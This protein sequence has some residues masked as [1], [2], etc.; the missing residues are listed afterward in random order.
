MAHPFTV[1]IPA[2]NEARVIG[3]TLAAMASDRGEDE[4]LILVVCN[5]CS[6]ETAEFARAAAPNAEV[7]EIGEASKTA[8]INEGLKRTAAFPVLIVDADVRIAH[9]DMAALAS[10]LRQSGVMAASPAPSVRVEGSDRWIR[11]YYRVWSRHRYRASGVGGSGVYGLSAEGAERI[12]RFPRII[13]DDT[14]VR[15]FFDPA[16]QRRVEAVDGRTVRS[17]VEAPRRV[18]DLVACEA[19]WH[20]GNVALRRMLPEPAPAPVAREQD[21]KSSL[22]DTAIY[23]AIKAMGRVRYGLNR[24]TGRAGLWHRDNSR[25]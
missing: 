17:L 16:E 3:R 13:A 24:V 11:A 22:A 2:H 20:A 25:R 1:I 7:I 19:R 23:L 10:V 9:R 4:P 21:H 12:G 18:S 15:W 6:D 5:G 14:Y 8:A